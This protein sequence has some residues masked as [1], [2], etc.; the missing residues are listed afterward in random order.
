V[1]Y[2][3]KRMRDFP[4]EKLIIEQFKKLIRIQNA[5]ERRTVFI[6]FNEQ[7]NK[8]LKGPEDQAILK[9][10]DF[11]AWLESKISNEPLE[12]ILRKTE[13]KRELH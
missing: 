4:I 1:R 11:P 5:A 12:D 3:Q 7:F 6:Y 2:L 13:T 8:L 10:F 9:Y